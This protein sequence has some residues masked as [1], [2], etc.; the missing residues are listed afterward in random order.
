MYLYL[1]LSDDGIGLQLIVAQAHYLSACD[2]LSLLANCFHDLR[3]DFQFYF[4]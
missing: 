4:C 2:Y 1:N 3:Y